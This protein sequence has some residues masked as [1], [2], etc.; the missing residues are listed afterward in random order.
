MCLCVFVFCIYV[1]LCVFVCIYVSINDFVCLVYVCYVI[2]FS[3]FETGFWLG[4]LL[5]FVNFN[6]CFG[7]V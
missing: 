5:L 4:F 3:F 6:F 7:G 1:C 2:F